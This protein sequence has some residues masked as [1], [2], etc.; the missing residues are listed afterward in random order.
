MRCLTHLLLALVVVAAVGRPARAGELD[1][2]E[3]AAQID[4]LVEARL[5]SEGVTPADPADDAEF[6]RRVYLD[7]H[8]VVPTWEQ[9]ERFL[10]DSHPNTR[11]RLVDSLLASPRYGEYLADMWQGYLISPLADDPKS[12]ADR[13]R[14]WL[15]DRF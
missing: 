7:L 1:G 9:A 11:S 6:L 15:A 8:G 10:S 14:P 4:R 5:H 2:A 13:L 12:R 3:L